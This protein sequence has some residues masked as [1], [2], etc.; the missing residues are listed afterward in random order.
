[1]G[2]SP[3]FPA[4]LASPAFTGAPT[5]P[6]QARGN[7]TTRL[8]TT[9]FV[10][11]TGPAKILSGPSTNSRYF[12]PGWSFLHTGTYESLD[13]PKIVFAPVFFHYR[14]YIE[15]VNVRVLVASGTPGA[16]LRP[17]LAL[18]N[19]GVP[20]SVYRDL[21]YLDVE[22]TGVKSVNVQSYIDIGFYWLGFG[23]NAEAVATS[24][25]AIRRAPITGFGTFTTEPTGPSQAFYNAIPS[26]GDQAVQPLYR[27]LQMNSASL[28]SWID[29][30]YPATFT[31]EDAP[32]IS[33]CDFQLGYPILW[34]EQGTPP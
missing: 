16:K 14:T 32:Y 18:D 5:A 10:Q 1:M 19:A 11:Q 33:E 4:T 25:H 8:A 6:T 17:V 7:S 23:I 27:I 9:E 29:S 20:G 34:F 12:F 22:T 30:G 24:V 26:I 15:S 28:Q 2:N 31:G 13:D 21:G 3:L